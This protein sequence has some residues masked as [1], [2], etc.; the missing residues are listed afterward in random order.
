M[1]RVP[2]GAVFAFEAIYRVYDM[3][4][5]NGVGEDEG[6]DRRYYDEVVLP[7]LRLLELDAIGGSTSRGYGQIKLELQM[8]TI[9]I[10]PREVNQDG[11]ISEPHDEA[12]IERVNLPVSPQIVR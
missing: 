4:D 12:E 10:A 11:T 1:E 9:R 7:A 2:A 8:Q 5:E 3:R 6:L